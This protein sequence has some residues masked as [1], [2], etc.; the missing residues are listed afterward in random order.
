MGFLLN[1]FDIFSI[2]VKWKLFL[3]AGFLG[4]YTTFSAYTLET[5]Q[6]FLDGNIKHALANILLNNIL[7]L[8]F[9]LLGMWLN[10]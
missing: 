5:A 9:L 6:F 4:G 8:F 7:C 10:R 1:L 2:N 3:T